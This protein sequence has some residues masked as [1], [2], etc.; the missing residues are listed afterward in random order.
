MKVSIPFRH[1]IELFNGN[2]AL[3]RRAVPLLE[4]S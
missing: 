3:P 2:R 1:G 4:A